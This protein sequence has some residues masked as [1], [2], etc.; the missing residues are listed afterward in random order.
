MYIFQYQIIR[1]LVDVYKFPPDSPSP[2]GHPSKKIPCKS[3][4]CRDFYF[5][6]MPNLDGTFVQND[7]SD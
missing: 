6:S 3:N 7:N 4:T 5:F 1:K 2:T